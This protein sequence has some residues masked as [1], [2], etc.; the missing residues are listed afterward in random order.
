MQRR[1]RGKATRRWY[2]WLY[3]QFTAAKRWRRL[4]FGARYVH[5]K[6]AAVELQRLGRGWLGRRAAWQLW[7]AALEAQREARRAELVAAW[8]ERREAKRALV[9][10]VVDAAVTFQAMWRGR[11]ARRR[12]AAVKQGPPT[13]KMRVRLPVG[14]TVIL[15]HPTLP[16]VRVSIWMERGCQQNDSLADG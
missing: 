3:T 5:R 1:W 9:Q 7:L 6:S 15:L 12:V 2:A 14:E 8:W 4:A 10:E 16:S 13:G 11:V